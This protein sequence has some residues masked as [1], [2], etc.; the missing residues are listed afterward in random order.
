MLGITYLVGFY[1][2]DLRMS[3]EIEFPPERWAVTLRSHAQLVLHEPGVHL[4]YTP[5]PLLERL[6]EDAQEVHQ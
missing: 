6:I 3:T 2:V 5:P 4:A 1:F